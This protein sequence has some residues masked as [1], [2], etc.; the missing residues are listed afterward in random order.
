MIEFLVDCAADD[1]IYH[2]LGNWGKEVDSQ[3]SPARVLEVHTLGRVIKIEVEEHPA[4]MGDR[5]AVKV[6]PCQVDGAPDEVA[7]YYV[8]R[9]LTRFPVHTAVRLNASEGWW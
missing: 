1:F 7:I 3:G 6:R 4:P 9:L 2:A 8:T 5:P